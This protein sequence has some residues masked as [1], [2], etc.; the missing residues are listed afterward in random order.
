MMNI[1]STIFCIILGLECLALM[2]TF[3]LNALFSLSSDINAEKRRVKQEKRDIEY[4]N[5]RMR[6]FKR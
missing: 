4:H 1:L 6:E 5:A 2:F 3:I